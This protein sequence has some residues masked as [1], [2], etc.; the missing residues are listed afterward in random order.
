MFKFQ[1]TFQC[2]YLPASEC[3]ILSERFAFTVNPLSYYNIKS[4]LPINAISNCHFI[5]IL[6]TFDWFL[7]IK[8]SSKCNYNHFVECFLHNR[9][10]TIVNSTISSDMLIILYNTTC[11][12]YIIFLIDINL[13]T[14]YTRC[15][16][17]RCFF[18][19][20][21]NKHNGFSRFWL[22]NILIYNQISCLLFK[23]KIFRNSVWMSTS[24][25][26][27]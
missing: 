26:I 21:I 17:C 8:I 11:S 27:V 5:P 22:Y 20:L 18:F 15:T 12:L 7:F 2:I 9:N 6:G 14:Y 24:I 3:L 23:F 10:T 19:F 16:V 25:S 4:A 13:Y 1:L